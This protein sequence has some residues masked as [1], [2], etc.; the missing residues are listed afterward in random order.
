[1]I[2]LIGPEALNLK[3]AVT[4]GYMDLSTVDKRRAILDRE[5]ELNKPAAPSIYRKVQTIVRRAT[6]RWPSAGLARWSTGS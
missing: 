1:M 3:R 6:G 2:F 5:Y 4:C